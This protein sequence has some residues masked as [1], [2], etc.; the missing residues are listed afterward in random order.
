MDPQNSL[1]SQGFRTILNLHN[2]TKLN[3]ACGRLLSSGPC[4]NNNHLV[5]YRI[6]LNL[7]VFMF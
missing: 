1:A 6:Q 2:T 4:L 3:L 7:L 5:L